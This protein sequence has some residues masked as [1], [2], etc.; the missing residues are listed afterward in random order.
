MAKQ[1]LRALFSIF[2]FVIW[3]DF[4]PLT[5]YRNKKA[6][7]VAFAKTWPHKPASPAQ[8]IQRAKMSEAAAAWQTLTPAEQYQWNLATRR[9]SLCCH[10]FDLFT[11]WHMTG[12]TTAIRTLERQTR[13]TLLP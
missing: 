6:R 8:V 7:V 12:D 2:G 11:H 3:G 13:T 10:G 9:A 4:G 1:P 5:M